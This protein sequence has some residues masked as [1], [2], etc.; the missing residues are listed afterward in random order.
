MQNRSRRRPPSRKPVEWRQLC[1]I[2]EAVIEQEPTISDSEWKARIRDRLASLEFEQPATTEPI[3]RAMSA[4]EKAL[5]KRRG[6]RPPPLQPLRPVT[7]ANPARPM[8]PEEAATVLA[9]VNACCKPPST[10]SASN[11]GLTSLAR[12]GIDASPSRDPPAN[13]TAAQISQWSAS[14]TRP[15][16]KQTSRGWVHVG[17]ER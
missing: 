12:I 11:S 14:T 4:V 6:P 16:W 1:K 17:E 10:A 5:E 13:Q 7:A 15:R 9:R 3:H 8:T 2:T